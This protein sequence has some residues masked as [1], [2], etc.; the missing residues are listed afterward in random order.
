MT[1]I[2]P[3]H[4]LYPEVMAAAKKEY[5]EFV[6]RSLKNGG[7]SPAMLTTEEDEGK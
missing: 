4:P 7:I 1:V 6:A 2:W 5:E 3:T